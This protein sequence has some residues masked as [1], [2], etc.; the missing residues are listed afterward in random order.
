MRGGIRARGLRK[1]INVLGTVLQEIG[2]AKRGRDMDGLRQ[3][4]AVDHLH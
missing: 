4:V 1:L 2:D 3:P